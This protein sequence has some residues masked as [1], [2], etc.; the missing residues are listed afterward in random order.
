MNKKSSRKTEYEQKGLPEDDLY[1]IKGTPKKTCVIQRPPEEEIC[2][3]NKKATPKRKYV[4]K[5][6]PREEILYVIKK[7]DIAVFLGILA[8]T[9]HPDTSNMDMRYLKIAPK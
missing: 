9:W 8:S 6:A 4:L 7:Y 5:K 3:K 1:M 2:D